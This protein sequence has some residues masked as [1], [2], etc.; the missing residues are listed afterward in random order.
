MKKERKRENPT[1]KYQCTLKA[2]PSRDIVVC[3][4]LLL[5]SINFSSTFLLCLYVTHC[6]CVCVFFTRAMRPNTWSFWTDFYLNRTSIYIEHFY[7]NRKSYLCV[8]FSV[9]YSQHVLFNKN[10]FFL[11]QSN[12]TRKLDEYTVIWVHVHLFIHSTVS[13]SMNV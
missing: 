1:G 12:N 8:S 5:R 13:H 6:L 3:F 2:R 10:R 7:T 11:S 4:I 9:R